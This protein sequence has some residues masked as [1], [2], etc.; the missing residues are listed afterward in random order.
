MSL[1]CLSKFI[2]IC[3]FRAACL[4]SLRKFTTSLPFA[5]GKQWR[6]RGA[7]FALLSKDLS[8][9]SPPA[10]QA[11]GRWCCGGDG[12]WASS[13]FCAVSCPGGMQALASKETRKM[14]E[15]DLW[16]SDQMSGS[17]PFRR[18]GPQLGVWWMCRPLASLSFLNKLIENNNSCE[19]A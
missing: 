10:L 14:E 5:S 17:G 6:L 11:Q 1:F 9:Q 7:A 16:L 3:Y 19:C 18:P 2:R 15:E 8:S 12:T 4:C 13:H